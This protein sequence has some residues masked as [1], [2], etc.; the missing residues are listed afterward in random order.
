VPPKVSTTVEAVDRATQVING[1][2]TALFL[3]DGSTV[4]VFMRAKGP[5]G[6]VLAEGGIA[7]AQHGMIARGPTVLVGEGQY[8][9]PF[10][11]GAEAILPLD[12]R[13]IGVLATAIGM[14]VDKRGRP[15]SRPGNVHLNFYGPTYGL[16]DFN[17]QVEYAVV[18]ALSQ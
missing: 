10:G 9:T 5:G 1:V 15:D 14:A 4:T 7:R 6:N 13:G 16:A 18:E 11:R 3:L 8:A 17:R 2:R 12:S